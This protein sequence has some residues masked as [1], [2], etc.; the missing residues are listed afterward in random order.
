MKHRTELMIKAP[1]N[2]VPFGNPAVEPGQ[3]GAGSERRRPDSGARF[4]HS[5]F[6]ATT[7]VPRVIAALA[8]TTRRT[9]CCKYRFS[10]AIELMAIFTGGS[11]RRRTCANL[12]RFKSPDETV[13][14]VR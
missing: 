8:Q 5:R 7:I 6:G 2:L 4:Y 12:E 13:A 11:M 14:A 3:P 1:P 9:D 10:D